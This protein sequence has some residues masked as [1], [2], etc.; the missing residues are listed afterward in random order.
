LLFGA[1]HALRQRISGSLWPVNRP[2]YERDLASTRE[3]LG[4]ERFTKLWEQRCAMTMEQAVASA[5]DEPPDSSL[6][7]T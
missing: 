5:L 1:A 4:D 6:T 2:V 7:A 3:T